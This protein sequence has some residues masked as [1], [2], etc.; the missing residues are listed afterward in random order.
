MKTTVKIGGPWEFYDAFRIKHGL[1]QLPVA[2]GPEIAVKPG[3]VITIPVHVLRPMLAPGLFALA[4]DV[5]GGWTV[6]GGAGKFSV[7]LGTDAQFRMEVQIPEL[8]KDQLQDAKPQTL[9]A[10]VS[11]DQKPTTDLQIKVQLVSPS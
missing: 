7:A 3:S 1:W 8:S 11:Q 6:I 10:H 4:A 2:S 9:V 5:P